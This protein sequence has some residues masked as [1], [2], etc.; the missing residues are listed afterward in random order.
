MN[1]GNESVARVA[2]KVVKR[3]KGAISADLSENKSEINF[4]KCPKVPMLCDIMV[5]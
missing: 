1:S 4:Q 2:K 3:E 5:L